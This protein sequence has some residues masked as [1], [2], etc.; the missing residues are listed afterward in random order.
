LIYSTC[1]LEAE[2]C[3]E[4]VRAVLSSGKERVRQLDAA[5]VLA[6]LAER[7]VLNTDRA[8]RERWVRG[9]CL[10][11]LPGAGFQ[12]DGFFATILERQ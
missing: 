7:G 3:E 8:V 4:V 2:E 12:G 1:S 9:A 11:T 6:Q 10:R 5:P